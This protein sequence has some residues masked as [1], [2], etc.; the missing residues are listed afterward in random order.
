MEQLLAD[1]FGKS[2]LITEKSSSLVLELQGEAGGVVFDQLEK[3]FMQTGVPVQLGC[4]WWLIDN[5]WTSPV[6]ESRL[7]APSSA[8][9]SLPLIHLSQNRATCHY[10]IL[11]LAFWAMNRL[12]E[13]GSVNLDSHDRFCAS[14]SHAEK[15]EYLNRPLVDEWLHILGQVISTVW[16]QIEL[17]ENTFDFLLSH[18]V[19]RPSRYGFQ[20]AK[21]LIRSMAADFLK[22]RDYRTVFIGPLVRLNTKQALHPKDPFNAF[23]WMMSQSE[24]AGVQSTFNFI[25]DTNFGQHE[26]GYK[27]EYPAIRSLI[28]TIHERGHELGLHPSYRCYLQPERIQHEFIRLKQICQEEDVMQERWGGRMH[29]LRWSQPETLRALDGVGLSFDSS[30][31]FVDKAGFRC[32]TCFSFTPFDALTNESFTLR[33]QPLVVMEAS[34]LSERYMGIRDSAQALTMMEDLKGKCRK[35]GGGF[36]LLWHNSELWHKSQRDLYCEVLDL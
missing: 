26:A 31:G 1:R 29:Y 13:I 11:G 20:S 17:K 8:P 23:D 10:D 28:R 4:E 27:L 3:A 34:I 16:P 6:D 7:P 19:D 25:S 22:K 35:L 14:E 12:E 24:R 30:L 15:F 32:G 5:K 9:L 21:G 18:D 2:W 36:S 33:E